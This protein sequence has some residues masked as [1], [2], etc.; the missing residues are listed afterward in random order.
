MAE[1]IVLVMSI[2]REDEIV[3]MLRAVACGD[4]QIYEEEEQEEEK[5]RRK[6]KDIEVESGEARSEQSVRSERNAEG[7]MQNADP[8]IQRARE[9]RD[10]SPTQGGS[11]V[12]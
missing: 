10:L 5:R 4:E 12:S 3:V 7:R 1:G 9:S 8:K 2:V 11:K 6:V